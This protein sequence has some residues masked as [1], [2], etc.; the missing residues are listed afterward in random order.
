[1]IDLPEIKRV[2][3]HRYPM[4]LIDRVVEIEGRERLTAIK[5][6]S[7]NEPWYRALG[8]ARTDEE[9]AYP[10]PLLVES[11]GQAAAVLAAWD[12]R[13]PDVLAGQV[14][15]FGS[16]TG[17]RFHGRVLPGDV[18]EHRVRAVR[19]LS[20][21]AIFEGETLVGSSPVL[22]VERV[23]MAMRPADV[24]RPALASQPA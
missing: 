9:H 19:Y 5:A 2:L 15:L 21:A 11:F 3:P 17:V 24:L 7:G 6:V 18:L 14:M 10:Q 22:E 16:M 13:N 23:V 4:L 8:D 12:Q 1:M 20:D